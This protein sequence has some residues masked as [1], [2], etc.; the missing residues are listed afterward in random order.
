MACKRQGISLDVIGEQFGT[1]TSRPENILPK[2]DLVFAKARCALEA[3]AVGC[4]VIVCDFGGLGCLVN[5]G[6]FAQMRELNFGGGVLTRPLDA[7]LI[8][9]EILKYNVND[10]Q[11]VSDRVRH[12]AGL[13]SSIDEWI[14]LYQDVQTEYV[15]GSNEHADE[16][17]ALADYVVEWGYD[18][19]IAWEN[20]RLSNYLGW[21]IV[22]AWL[23]RLLRR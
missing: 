11:L 21:P 3:M 12:E 4:A 20:Q 8:E 15:P 16:L 19:R 5:L 23:R 14:D 10:A 22:G 13:S 6:T 17:A 7:A 1:P 2:Y 9:A 18:A